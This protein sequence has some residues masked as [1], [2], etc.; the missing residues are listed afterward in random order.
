MLSKKEAKTVAFFF[1][2]VKNQSLF[3]VINFE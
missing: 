2:I 1:S 3:V